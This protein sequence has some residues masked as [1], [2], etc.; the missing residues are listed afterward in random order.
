[1]RT[2]SAAPTS[3][4]SHGAA[5]TDPTL[6]QKQTKLL[7]LPA[8]ASGDSRFVLL[9]NPRTGSRSRY[10]FCP[11]LGVFEFTSLTLPASSPRSVLFVRE[12]FG[13]D[14]TANDTES[15]HGNGNLQKEGFTSKAAELFIATPIDL[16]FF[17]LPI[18]ST[19]SKPSSRRLF[20]PLDDILDTREDLSTHLRHI[21][22]DKEFRPKIEGRM[23]AVCDTVEAGE[24]MFRLNENK[25]VKELLSKS[26]NMATNG[27]PPS[28]EERFVQRALQLPVL[29]ISSK[30][31]SQSPSDIL[32]GSN[33]NMIRNDCESQS[34]GT[35]TIDHTPSSISSTPA[36]DL[37]QSSVSSS[38]PSTNTEIIQLLRVR[39]A[40]QYIQSSYLPPQLS[41]KISEIV[42]SPASPKDFTSLDQHLEYVAK[43]RAEVVASRTLYDNVSRK[44][45]L[46]D[47]QVEAA[48]EKKR[49]QEEEEKKKKANQSRGIK[50]LKKVNTS[51]MKK[52]SSF[53]GKKT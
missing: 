1:M 52:L 21:L 8:G 3:K 34:S 43:L 35:T 53:F 17:L 30:D 4:A 48:S 31:D 49:K 36:T 44:R 13:Q 42:A 41:A 18:L 47:E 22:L 25:L 29:S 5:E 20:Q 27:L 15:L 46:D 26:E 16:L 45:M 40:L 2:R 9:E 39:T 28:M 38:T 37:S 7:I 12:Q 6:P 14:D 33:G 50:D 11:K 24:T 19:P 32:S 23:T 10:Y 51:G